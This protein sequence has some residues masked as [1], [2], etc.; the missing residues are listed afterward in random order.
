M[1]VRRICRIGLTLLALAG[2]AHAYTDQ[3]FNNVRV[4]GTLQCLGNAVNCGTGGGGGGLS[5]VFQTTTFGALPTCNSGLSNR[6]A[7]ITDSLNSCQA[8]NALAG[9]GVNRCLLGCDGVAWNILGTV[10][11]GGGGGITAPV[12]QIGG[13]NSAPTFRWNPV[14][15][16]SSPTTAVF[17][18]A[19]TCNGT[20]VAFTLPPSTGSGQAVSVRGN[21]GA[22]N[23]IISTQGGNTI[24][25][26]V[27]SGNWGVV[28]QQAFIL[29]DDKAGDWN[30][31][32]N[33]FIPPGL[34]FG[35]YA[36]ATVT[37]D[38]KGDITAISSNPNPVTSVTASAPLGSTVG[39]TPN[40]SLSNSGV[41]PGTYTNVN[42]TVDSFG[43]VTSIS[44]GAGGVTSVTAGAPIQSS[45][46]A[47]PNITLATSGVSAGSYTCANI[48]VGA[49]GLLTSATSGSC[50]GGGGGT[51]PFV[52][53]QYATSVSG[54]TVSAGGSQ[55]IPTSTTLNVAGATGFPSTAGNFRV[56]V[57]GPGGTELVCTG[58]NGGLTA[59]TGCGNASGNC[60]GG[61]PCVITNGTPITPVVF[62]PNTFSY[63]RATTNNT[64]TTIDFQAPALPAFNSQ[65]TFLFVEPGGGT[66]GLAWNDS[67]ISFYI[68]AGFTVN[69]ASLDDQ[70]WFNPNAQT[71]W[72]FDWDPGLAVWQ[73]SAKSLN[74]GKVS[75]GTGTAIGPKNP[76]NFNLVGAGPVMPI[77]AGQWTE[78]SGDNAGP[79]G[80]G[81]AWYYTLWTASQ[82]CNETSVTAQVSYRCAIGTGLLSSISQQAPQFVRPGECVEPTIFLQA[83]QST[84]TNRL[85]T[86]ANWIG[87]VCYANA[88][89]PLKITWVTYNNNGDSL[90]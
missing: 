16:I 85:S 45:G 39:T 57:G 10:A 88:T 35:T 37:V 24:I 81:S 44:N 54:T 25:G 71:A 73:R 55:T 61:T 2:T 13:I 29:V 23:C 28:G 26:T 1:D 82:L 15:V 67:I 75:G 3:S 49:N 4:F 65:L 69:G 7:V 83:Q 41:T 19:Y 78:V 86:G 90:Y 66:L 18:G 79:P 51:G 52:T 48:T 27:V 64:S 70:P 20:N 34:T 56:M 47:A 59:F 63:C 36:N 62:C 60:S 74:Q 68:T 33:Y 8:G 72:K 30:V 80:G 6:T 42:A 14:S 22:T 84:F 38:N 31:Y 32:Y 77:K 21:G 12:G 87:D 11:G 53:G 50:G 9:S 76:A 46:G 5:A 17:G 43:R 89:Q 40:I 58:V